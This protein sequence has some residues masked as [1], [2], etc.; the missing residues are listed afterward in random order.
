MAEVI[1]IYRNAVHLPDEES[2]KRFS[3]KARQLEIIKNEL[4]YIC[5]N[6]QDLD[7]ACFM[8]IPLLD[9]STLNL[10]N[11]LVESLELDVRR[12]RDYVNE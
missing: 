2:N 8:H 9:S 6:L 7:V 10:Y 11:A 3:R 1:P 12:I 4:R 5:D